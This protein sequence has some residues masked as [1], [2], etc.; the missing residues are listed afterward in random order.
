MRL[1]R[2]LVRSLVRLVRSLVC[3][4]GGRLLGR[5]PAAVWQSSHLVC[6][7]CGTEFG[8]G[9]GWLLVPGR[10]PD[11]QTP[12]RQG[13]TDLHIVSVAI[14]CIFVFNRLYKFDHDLII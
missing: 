2:S 7:L 5:L 4:L 8:P 10:G 9:G 3:P 6:T 14:M 1:V 12:G 11:K 13:P